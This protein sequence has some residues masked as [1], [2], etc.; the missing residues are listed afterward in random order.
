MTKKHTV[1]PQQQQHQLKKTAPTVFYQFSQ[2][3]T[4]INKNKMKTQAAAEHTYE[5]KLIATMHSLELKDD[6]HRSFLI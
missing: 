6:E 3:H 5:N 1:K 2:H 4:K